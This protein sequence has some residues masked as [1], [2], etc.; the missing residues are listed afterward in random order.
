MSR[1]SCIALPEKC[2]NGSN[3]LLGEYSTGCQWS[4]NTVR[5]SSVQYYMSQGVIWRVI[6]CCHGNNTRMRENMRHIFRSS[7]L[8]WV[9]VLL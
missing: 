4:D 1:K 7:W 2:R 3:L 9:A 8:P 5:I 6:A